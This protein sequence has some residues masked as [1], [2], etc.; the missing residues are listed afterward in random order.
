MLR[1][2][3]RHKL[4]SEG[5][6][7]LEAN[8]VSGIGEQRDHAPIVLMAPRERRYSRPWLDRLIAEHVIDGICVEVDVQQCPGAVTASFLSPADPT[9]LDDS[10]AVVEV[11]DQALNPDACR[12]HNASSFG[13]ESHLQV[14]L[15]R[16]DDRW[17][18]ADVQMVEGSTIIC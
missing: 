2:Y 5:D 7:T 8:L 13:G 14:R 16:R 9:F 3:S 12:R 1:L 6:I 17:E 4:R 18:L 11:Y 15:A 10:A